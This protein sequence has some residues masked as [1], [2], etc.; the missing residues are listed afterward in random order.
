[1]TWHKELIHATNECA[2]VNDEEAYA[3]FG[4]SAVMDEV[5]QKSTQPGV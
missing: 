3:K 5:G 2:L 4:C 1:M